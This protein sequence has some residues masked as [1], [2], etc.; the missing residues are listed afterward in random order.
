MFDYQE[1]KTY[2][3]TEL[4]SQEAAQEVHIKQVRGGQPLS[5][6]VSPEDCYLFDAHGSAL[7]RHGSQARPVSPP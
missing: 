5:L 2:L 1:S 6:R 7:P 4:N 3:E